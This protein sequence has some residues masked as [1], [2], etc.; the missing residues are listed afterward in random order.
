MKNLYNLTQWVSRAFIPRKYFIN[1]N[2]WVTLNLTRENNP[3]LRGISF[4]PDSGSP[5]CEAK[6]VSLQGRQH[7]DFDC[8][9]P[10]LIIGSDLEQLS[11]I[12]QTNNTFY[13]PPFSHL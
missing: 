5:T 4:G 9:V 3:F 1:L 6:H 12:S 11:V 13:M 10:T 7:M 2:Q 8:S